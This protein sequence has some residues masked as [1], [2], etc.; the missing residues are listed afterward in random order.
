MSFHEAQRLY[1]R[2]EDHTFYDEATE[3]EMLDG[4]QMKKESAPGN[5]IDNLFRFWEMVLK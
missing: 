3:E 5:E 1:D 4:E 2:Q